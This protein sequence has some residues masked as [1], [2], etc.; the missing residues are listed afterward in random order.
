MPKN[1]RMSLALLVFFAAAIFFAVGDQPRAVTYASDADDFIQ[2]EVL[3]KLTS[4][5]HLAPVAA[6][7]NLDPNPLDQFGS[8]PIYR[9]RIIDKA[10]VEDR[11]DQLVKDGRVAL[12]EPNYIEKPPEGGGNG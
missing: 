5:I 7:Y 11:I 4:T 1:L 2:G 6:Q 3:V 9:L 8:R 10:R 12:A